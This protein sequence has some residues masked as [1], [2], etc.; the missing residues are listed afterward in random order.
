VEI[1]LTAGVTGQQGMILPLVFPVVRVTLIVTVD[2]S[3]YLIWALNLTAD[4]S[5]YLAGLT[6]FECGFLRLPSWTH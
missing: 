2:Y 3:M 5:V 1:G 6:D 4:F